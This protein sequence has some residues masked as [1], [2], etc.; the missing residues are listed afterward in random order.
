MLQWIRTRSR[1]DLVLAVLVAGGF[2]FGV[3]AF[4]TRGVH[5]T[6]RGARYHADFETSGGATADQEF[7]VGADGSLDIQVGD[8]DVSVSSRSGEARVIFRVDG[9]EVSSAAAI[10][11]FGFEIETRNGEL[12]IRSEEHQGRGWDDRGHDDV[13]IE[14]TV[15]EDFDIRVQTGDGDIAVESF[16][17]EVRLQTG[18]GDIAIEGARGDVLHLHTGD[19][20]VA[21]GEVESR[22]VKIQTGDG[23][24]S[25]HELQ[26]VDVQVQTG[27]GDMNLRGVSGALVASTGDGDIRVEIRQFGGVRIRSGD[28]DVTVL[29]P[30]GIAADVT[31]RGSEFDVAEAF[32]LSINGMESRR[33]EGSLNGGGPELSIRVGDG[34][35][36]LIER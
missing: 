13:S 21:V 15:P 10:E 29:A 9:D 30:A 5:M 1:R 12:R 20:D 36:R 31:L 2:F 11:D 22:D 32:G 16:A 4:L 25:V 23:D 33:V 18:D 7:D 14:V 28:G 34:T 17:G 35:I 26:A 8:A 24:V 19:G 6:E 27:D 3:T